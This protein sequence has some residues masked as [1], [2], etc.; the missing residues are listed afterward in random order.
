MPFIL[1]V[2]RSLVTISEKVIV[3]ATCVFDSERQN[4]SLTE[5]CT[6]L[7]ICLNPEKIHQNQKSIISGWHFKDNSLSLC[8]EQINI[9]ICFAC[10]QNKH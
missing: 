9:G 7:E 2:Y 3:P 5:A 8:Y 1:G 4:Y 10:N 6:A